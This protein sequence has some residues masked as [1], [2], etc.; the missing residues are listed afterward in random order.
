MIKVSELLINVVI[1]E[2]A[3]VADKPDP[4]YGNEVE[5]FLCSDGNTWLITLP[6]KR[7]NLSCQHQPCG[8]W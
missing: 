8:T 2:Q 3:K 1:K 7:Q 6:A 4:K 5:I